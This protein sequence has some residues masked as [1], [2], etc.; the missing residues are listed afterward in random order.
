MAR[1]TRV[2]STSAIHDSINKSLS[3]TAMP[4]HTH[5]AIYSRGAWFAV[6]QQQSFSRTQCWQEATCFMEITLIYYGPLE[7]STPTARSAANDWSGDK[8]RGRKGLLRRSTSSLRDGGRFSARRIAALQHGNRLLQSQT[9]NSR[10]ST[11]CERCSL[12]HGVG[13]PNDRDS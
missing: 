2:P 6:Q 1:V 10:I 9:G 4:A 7:G 11:S 8:G 13:G 5:M 12:Q 3:N